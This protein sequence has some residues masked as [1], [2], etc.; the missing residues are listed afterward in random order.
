MT[1]SVR[2]LA[3]FKDFKTDKM[4]LHLTTLCIWL[5]RASNTQIHLDL[6]IN[7]YRAQMV[8]CRHSIAAWLGSY[9]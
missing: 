3:S 2:N 6:S 9:K 4:D 1:K 7:A 5:K 8:G